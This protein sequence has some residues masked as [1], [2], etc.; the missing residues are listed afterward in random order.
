MLGNI[1]SI[2]GLVLFVLAILVSVGLLIF[3]LVRAVRGE[4]TITEWATEH[5]VRAVWLVAAS[6]V[7]SVGIGTHFYFFRN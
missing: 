7:G 2:T 6:L 5:R 3:D 1:L 4:L